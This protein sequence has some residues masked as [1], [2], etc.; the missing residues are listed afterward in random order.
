MSN[1][2]EQREI[3]QEVVMFFAKLSI[4]AFILVCIMCETNTYSVTQC[5]H[6]LYEHQEAM[7]LR[8][9]D[10]FVIPAKPSYGESAVSE[11]RS[12]KAWPNW[13]DG[14]A[15]FGF[16]CYLFM[17]LFFLSSSPPSF[18]VSLPAG[19]Q[20]NSVAPHQVWYANTIPT[21]VS[22]SLNIQM[23]TKMC[24]FFVNLQPELNC[25]HTFDD[26]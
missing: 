23:L 13:T 14:W 7:I 18:P 3:F 4:A 2:S 8:L 16:C 20:G 11:C 9:F 21:S 5:R 17:C 19:Q 22:L 26:I 6:P 15:L 12:D 10:L 24:A 1:K 25:F